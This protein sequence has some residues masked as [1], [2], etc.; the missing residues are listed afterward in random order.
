MENNAKSNAVLLLFG[1]CAAFFVATLA[2][3]AMSAPPLL[4][5]EAFGTTQTSA[6]DENFGKVNINTALKEELATLPGI[7]ET[8]A[9][10]IIAYR[11]ENGP[12]QKT[13]ELVNVG[14]IGEKKWEAIRELVCV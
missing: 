11:E 13:E 8:L 4:P 10:R 14:G 2:T 5:L 9:E 7:G 1:L 12:F 6:F 3:A